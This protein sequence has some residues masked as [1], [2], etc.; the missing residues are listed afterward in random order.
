MQ[1]EIAR[2]LEIVRSLDSPHDALLSG[3]QPY[4]SGISLD[5]YPPL[6]PRHAPFD[7]SRRSSVQMLEPLPVS[8]GQGYVGR[9]SN[10]P[11]SPRSY[12]ITNHPPTH[13]NTSPDSTFNRPPLPAQRPSIASA[14]PHDDAPNLARRHTSADIRQHGWPPN[15]PLLP[16]I[17]HNLN[18]SA[19]VSP[20]VSV[21]NSSSVW[22]SLPHRTTTS[23]NTGTNAP[24]LNDHQHIRDHLAGYEI[25]P[26]SNPSRRQ[27][28]SQSR[29]T[30]PPPLPG[31][32]S[33]SST[34]HVGLSLSGGSGIPGPKFPRL[35][36]D[37]HSAP[38]TR[39][40]SMASNVHSLLN[41]AETAEREDEDED[42]G[43]GVG[44][45]ERKRRR[46]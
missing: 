38:A 26:S 10:L 31:H 3:R 4:F 6:S 40:S 14:I 8:I 36:P 46:V 43:A 33:V 7:E 41:P 16:Q 27:P 13:N 22:P 37:L 39:R 18:A 5:A 25:N 28:L 19:N 34:E 1:K 23:S 21:N 2:Q 29:H 12:G 17:P 45:E 24:P 32:E 15:L 20:Y 11:S 9:P 30:T 42:G 35:G 44:G